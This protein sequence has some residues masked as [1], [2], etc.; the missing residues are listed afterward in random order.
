MYNISMD[1]Q[2]FGNFVKQKRLELGMSRD[3][4]AALLNI[5]P[6][7]LNNMER[8]TRVPSPELLIAL[9]KLFKMSS[10][11]LFQ[12]L[13]PGD[14]EVPASETIR[15][16]QSFTAQ[17]RHEVELFIR[18]KAWQKARLAARQRGQTRQ[19]LRTDIYSDMDFLEDPG[20]YSENNQ[21]GKDEPA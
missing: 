5:S 19:E 18:F 2:R 15:L 14:L 11:R 10:G 4:F 3:G 17:D 1:T 8:G 7:H 20:D 12:L 9:A 16:P 13:E 21:K 6:G